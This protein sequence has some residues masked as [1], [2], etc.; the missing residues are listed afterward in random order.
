MGDSTTVSGSLTNKGMSGNG[1]GATTVGPRRFSIEQIRR[2]CLVPYGV[3]IGT[4]VD[5]RGVGGGEGG[6]MS[7]GGGKKT[8]YLERRDGELVRVR[9]R[10][11]A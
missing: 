3:Q 7:M 8:S 2:Y 1:A 6:F 5:E 9:S 11:E 4:A 10:D